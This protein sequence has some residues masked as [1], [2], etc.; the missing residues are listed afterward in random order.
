PLDGRRDALG[1]F[2]QGEIAH[3][4]AAD[5]DV[6]VRGRVGDGVDRA[7]AQAFGHARQLVDHDRSNFGVAIRQDRLPI[8]DRIVIGRGSADAPTPAA[9]PGHA[10]PMKKM[11]APMRAESAPSTGTIEPSEA[12][13]RATRP[14]VESSDA[15]APPMISHFAIF[16]RPGLGARGAC[17]STP[18][19]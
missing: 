19:S 18:W 11:T 7:A 5:L 15:V 9:P 4:G 10:P 6:L 3:G 17:G 8:I 2:G 12:S 1:G 14:I 13:G 16:R